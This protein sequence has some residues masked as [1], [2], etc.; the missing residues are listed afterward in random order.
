MIRAMSKGPGHVQRAL[1]AI[2]AGEPGA[3]FTI[4]MLACRVYHLDK[5]ERRHQVALARA[6]RSK[7][8]QTFCRQHKWECWCVGF[9]HEF[10]IFRSGA[11]RDRL[12]RKLLET[13]DQR[14]QHRIKAITRGWG[15]LMRR[16]QKS[17]GI[18]SAI[19]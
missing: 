7:A 12:M 6:L 18:F 16:T 11:A 1:L 4:E 9:T 10:V 5:A 13:G 19:D 3:A 8:V 14:N 17:Y 15:E 2:L